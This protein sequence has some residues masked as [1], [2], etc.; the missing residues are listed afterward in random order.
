LEFLELAAADDRAYL[1]TA[2]AAE[3]FGVTPEAIHRWHRLGYVDPVA[4]SKRD[5]SLWE[6]S[7]LAEAEKR[8]RDAA[9]ATS[10]TDKRARRTFA[11]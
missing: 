2:K 9:V 8:A 11:A 7:A 1:R 6:F 4:T 3:A 5:G 10:G